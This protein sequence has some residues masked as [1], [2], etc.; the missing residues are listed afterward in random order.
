MFFTETELQNKVIS[1]PLS[2]LV[3]L[4]RLAKKRPILVSYLNAHVL[5]LLLVSKK[6]RNIFAQVDYFYPDGWGGVLYLYLLGVSVSQRST[7]PD[8]FFTLLSK[9]WSMEKVFLLG[10]TVKTLARFKKQV[11]FKLPDL[12]IVGAQHGYFKNSQKVVDRIVSKKPTVL[13]VGMGADRF[14]QL[15]RQENWILQHVTT[16]HQP[17]FVWCV[18]DLFTQVL[19]ERKSQS[20]YTEWWQRTRQ[21]P[22]KM[23][24]RYV[25]DA[26]GLVL[27]LLLTMTR[28]LWK[29]HT[30]KK[31]Y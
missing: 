19:R 27:V 30:H 13:I 15:P 2:E 20:W 24:P 9:W 5:A 18:G 4:Q 22:S 16:M 25:F 7:A 14:W 12:E 28:A 6:F 23:L 29:Q 21:N 8:F 26:L 11:S 17:I 3:Q 1:D 10:S 31:K